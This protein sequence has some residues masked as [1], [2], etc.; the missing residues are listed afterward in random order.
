MINSTPSRIAISAAFL[1]VTCFFSVN[2]LQAE[3]A[4]RVQVTVPF[5]FCVGDK[6]MA[7]DITPGSSF[8]AG[9]PRLLFEGKFETRPGGMAEPDYDISPDGQHFL[10][11]KASAQVEAEAQLHVVLNWFTEL[12]Q[13]VPVH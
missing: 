12:K 10:M 6:M 9:T 5:D 3:I 4:H 7:V 1:L 13:R 8:K 11:I 2:S